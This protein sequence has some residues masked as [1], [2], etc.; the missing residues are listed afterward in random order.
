[1]FDL[2]L[3]EIP[4]PAGK[5]ERD[6]LISWMI[7]TLCLH[8]RREDSASD[9]EGHFSPIHRILSEHLLKNPSKGF[10]TREL[11]EELGLT[12]AAIHHHFARL[13]S[14]G[15]VST[16]TGNGWKN[17]YLV[18]GSIN[19]AIE[20][21][22]SRSSIIH[23]Q[24]IKILDEIWMRGKNTTL[25]IELPPDGKPSA[26]IRIKE[27]GPLLENENEVSR[28]MADIGLLGERP[29][30]ENKQ[31]SLSVT[32]FQMLLKSGPPISIDE[33]AE[34]CGGPKPR[35]GRILERF[36][37]TG[38]VERVA[39]T[40]RL[41]PALWSAMTTQHSRRGEDWLLKKGG[42]Q[43]LSISNTIL[44]HLKNGSCTPE[45][46]SRSLKN[47]D[48][49]DQMLLLNLLGGRLPLGYRLVGT[50]VES[51]KRKSTDD[52]DRI[53]RRIERVGD[54]LSKTE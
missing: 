12:P 20:N 3:E 37:T 10:E 44:K 15:L 46:I 7:D 31:D 14:A 22:K 33:T 9:E 39:R 1:M 2:R 23:K 35:V 16:T 54:T 38:M 29:G 24:R 17:Y 52:L 11:A 28:F 43:R 41:S 13:V 8:R 36:R 50:D 42:F 45:I 32:V 26:L 47:I 34:A 25:K 48:A 18:G 27:W 30:K 5:K 40:D 21:M 4:L 19:N 6:K 49:K 51:L 53:F